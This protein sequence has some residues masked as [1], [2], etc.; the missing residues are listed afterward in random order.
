M[1]NGLLH[2]TIGEGRK[3]GKK[4]PKA[5][6][7]WETASAQG[8]WNSFTAQQQLA[9][10]MIG[11]NTPWGSLDYQ[12]TG[13]TWI[14][15]PTGKRIEVP[16]YTANVNLTSEQPGIFEPTQ[17]AARKLAPIA[18]DQSEWLGH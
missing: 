11:Q 15:D 3:L 7:P 9:M 16:T 8:A 18:K 14:T 17:A 12:Q 1:T 13:S 5:P 10:N 4:A 6:D 2:L